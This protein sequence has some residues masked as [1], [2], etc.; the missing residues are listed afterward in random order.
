VNAQLCQ[1]RDRFRQTVLVVPGSML[2]TQQLGAHLPA[3]KHLAPVWPL[4][5]QQQVPTVWTVGQRNAG[6][7]LPGWSI[8]RVGETNC[9]CISGIR[10]NHNP[11]PDQP[12][13]RL[14][15]E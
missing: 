6:H 12:S 2:P 5:N 13:C 10:I 14:E 3:G 15:A 1:Y 4:L 9:Q 8:Q 11:H 7:M